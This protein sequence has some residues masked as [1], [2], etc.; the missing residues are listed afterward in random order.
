MAKPVSLEKILFSQGFGTRRYC[1]DL[2]Y[3]DLVK[4]NGVVAEDPEERI[5]TEG[6]VLN[7]EGQDWEF[8]EKAY[9]AFNKPANYECSHKTSHHPSVYSLLPRPFV[10][11]GLQCVGRLDYDTTGLLLISDDGQF[12]H[13]MT[14]PKKNIGKVYEITTSEPITSK[15][16]EHLLKGVVLDDD[17]RP[18][19]AVA[20][21]QLTENTLAMT[22]VE[23]RYHQVKRMMAAVG[24]HV[25]R[26]HRTEIG[27][28]RMPADLAEGQWRWLYADELKMLSRSVEADHA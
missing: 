21:K 18:C 22:I 6:L 3:A 25:A 24:N 4:I 14:T 23:G 26:L 5:L 9:I 2:V 12:I 20:C 1:S 19:Q 28:Y 8:H 10:E 27:Q 16:I 11:R 17:P 7:V 13:K 15:Q